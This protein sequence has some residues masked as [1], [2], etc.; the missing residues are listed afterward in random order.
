MS[1]PPASE[2]RG[3]LDLDEPKEPIAPR[4]SAVKRMLASAATTALLQVAS[5]VLGFATSVVIAR[6][7][8]RDEYGRYVFALAWASL[9]IIPA[10]LGLDRFL[11]RGIAVYEEEKNWAHMRGL[12]RR[13]NQALVLT[14]LVIAG[15]G[16]LIALEWLAHPLRLPFCVA[17]LLVPFTA[18]TLARQAT[19][20]ALGRTITGQLPEYALRPVLIL[21]GVGI[22]AL[23]GK[24]D[25]TSSSALAVNVTGVALAFALGALLL[26]RALPAAMR[27]TKATYATSEWLRASLPMM[28]IN[29]IWAANSYVTTLAVGTLSGTR[30]AGVY[31][32]AQRGAELIVVL[33]LAA[34]M[35]L[36]PAI[37]K[38][39]TR[40]DRAGLEHTTE[41]VA[42]ATLLVSAPLAAVLIVFPG[43][44]LGIFG[45][46]FRTG[47]TALTILAVGQLVNAAVGPAGNVLL[48]T[49]NERAA[50]RG[51]GVGL[52]VNLVL[53]IVLVPGLGV[54]GGAIAFASS[55]VLWNIV[56]VVLAR[57]RVGINATAFSRLAMARPTQES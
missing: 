19:M 31:S 11:V 37:A 33:L 5:L 16:T 51:I 24:G 30:G 18:L 20:Q 54:T 9:L 47:T 14:S 12:L 28:L 56:L 43:L 10:V 3:V 25:L 6:T 45:T 32:V 35:P 15:A 42:Q 23:V 55:L 2:S 21:A 17:M 41:R 44:Y 40:G 38:L 39:H 46:A 34:N 52:L 27:S 22:L 8:G 13:T 29:G 48:M 50:M 7:L 1:E 36:A 26:R 4:Y 49:G 57:R 53:A